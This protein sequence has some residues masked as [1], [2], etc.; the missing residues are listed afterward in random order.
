MLSLRNIW[1]LALITLLVSVCDAPR[2]VF[3]QMQLYHIEIIFD[4]HTNELKTNSLDWIVISTYVI[5]T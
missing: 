5:E 3:Y 2:P 1:I 4:E